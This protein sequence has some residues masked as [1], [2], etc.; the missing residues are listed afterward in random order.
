MR[1]NSFQLVVLLLMTFMVC[2]GLLGGLTD[3]PGIPHK[4]LSSNLA[5]G[6]LSRTIIPHSLLGSGLAVSVFGFLWFVLMSR[7]RR[8]IESEQGEKPSANALMMVMLGSMSFVT[9]Y[10]GDVIYHL[11]H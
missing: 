7:L 6:K 4:L 3:F 2:V 9:F 8:L 1:I 11:A 5:F 10:L